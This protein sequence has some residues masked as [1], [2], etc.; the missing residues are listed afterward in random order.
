MTYQDYAKQAYQAYGKV[1]D[2]KN[3]QGLPMPKWEELPPKIQ[4]AW[5][6]AAKELVST[7]QDEA[8]WASLGPL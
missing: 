6:A 4:E 5:I 8:A 1:T 3:Y 2:F 7:A